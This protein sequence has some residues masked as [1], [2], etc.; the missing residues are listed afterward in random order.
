MFTPG[1]TVDSISLKIDEKIFCGDAA[2][3][4]LSSKKRLI[5]WI[6]NLD[7]FNTSWET[8]IAKNASK[9][10]PGYDSLFDKNDLAKYK[11]AISKIK[12]RP[13]K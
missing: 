10:Y 13:L 8:I 4:G 6:E 11:R 1:H 5:I 7:D 12:L 9:I 2:M 3:N